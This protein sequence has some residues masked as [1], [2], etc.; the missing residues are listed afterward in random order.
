MSKKLLPREDAHSAKLL[1]VAEYWR[2]CAALSNEPWRS[3]MMR[4]TAE[5][6][7]KAAAKAISQTLAPL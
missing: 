2:Q 3:D 1:D 7:E 6:F 4:A 5:E